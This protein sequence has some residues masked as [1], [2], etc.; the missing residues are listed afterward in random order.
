MMS[1]A[2]LTYGLDYIKQ[3]VA[4]ISRAFGRLAEGDALRKGK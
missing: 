1:K 2:I 4:E 3:S